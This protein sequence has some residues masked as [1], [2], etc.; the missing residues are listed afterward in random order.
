MPWTTISAPTHELLLLTWPPKAWWNMWE[1][2]SHI[3][4]PACCY[5][6]LLLD[7]EQ[8]NPS[9]P[10][11][12]L[13]TGIS[14][15]PYGR[16]HKKCHEGITSKLNFY[17]PTLPSCSYP[18]SVCKK[19]STPLPGTVVLPE[20]QPLGRCIECVWSGFGSGGALR[21]ATL[22]KC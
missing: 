14:L 2:T 11:L 7:I 5:G 13:W 8:S 18:Q 1:P 10:L 16:F 17:L 4:W 3:H 20:Q 6:H 15:L 19:T 12:F 9:V 22:R 21:V